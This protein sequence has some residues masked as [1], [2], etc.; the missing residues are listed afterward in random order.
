MVGKKYIYLIVRSAM[1]CFNLCFLFLRCFD[2]GDLEIMV[3]FS[4]FGELFKCHWF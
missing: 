3:K 1:L 2:F 4:L